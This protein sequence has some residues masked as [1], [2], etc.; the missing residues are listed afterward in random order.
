MFKQKI[1]NANY[2]LPRDLVKID[3]SDN[4]VIVFPELME[5]KKR[6]NDFKSVIDTLNYEK[7]SKVSYRSEVVSR[8]FKQQLQSKLPKGP[9]TITWAKLYEIY[10]TFPE[11]FAHDTIEYFDLCAA[12]G[13]FIIQTQFYATKIMRKK[14]NWHATTLNPFAARTKANSA[15]SETS[16]DPENMFR[17][18]L[19]DDYGLIKKNIDK[20]IFGPHNTGDIT[21]TENIQS[22]AEKLKNTG[23]NIITSDCGVG[24][25]DL[26]VHY[27]EQEGYNIGVAYGA[28]TTALATLS[29]GGSY[30]MK[31]FTLFE[32]STVS[33]LYLLACLF[34]NMHIT[35]PTTS[36]SDN[37]ELYI[38]CIGFK[39]IPPDTLADLY[40]VVDNF[41]PY[42]ALFTD[43][44]DEFI[45]QIADFMRKYD[46]R[47]I[48]AV[49]RI[50]KYYHNYDAK[51]IIIEKVKF[52]K[53]WF[54]QYT[55][56]PK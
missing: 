34:E 6:I 1:N 25:G 54:D 12:P 42:R 52:E 26:P 20:W 47:V 13:I 27:T 3:Y 39:G 33:L 45:K 18:R 36:K 46:D 21:D 51:N 9:L 10:C 35:K 22:F 30:I 31:T 32:S 24:Q 43:I 15:E 40:F 44:P 7:Y 41:D 2:Q 48:A 17:T 23:V 5:E 56:P 8:E 37:Q 38:V 4:S 14:I 11:I 29:K 50:V 49:N 28:T 19:A 16:V 53:D 55:L